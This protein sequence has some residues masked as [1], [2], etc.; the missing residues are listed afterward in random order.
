MCF[1]LSDTRAQA[2]DEMCFVH[3]FMDLTYVLADSRHKVSAM[4][5]CDPG[6]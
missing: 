5:F 4:I 2:T 6:L 1:P 3:A